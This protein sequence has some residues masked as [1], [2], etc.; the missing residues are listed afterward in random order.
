MRSSRNSGRGASGATGP[1]AGATPLRVLIVSHMHP[2]VTRGGAEIAAYQMYTALRE[3]PGITAWFCGGASASMQPPLGTHVFQPFGPDEFVIGNPGYDH[4][5]HSANNPRFADEFRDLV[6]ELKPDVVHFH[7]FVNLGVEALLQVKQAAPEARIVL[8]LHE[9]LAICYHFGQ[10]VKRPGMELCEA[11]SP[12][13]CA[14]CFP[15]K[16]D[17]DFFMRKLYIQRFMKLADHFISP[18]RFLADRYIAWG[19]E[20]DR[21]SVIENGQPTL[22]GEDQP[23]P[24]PAT[25]IVGFFGQLSTLKGVGL[26]MDA[27]DD[28]RR[29]PPKRGRLR[30]EI[31]GDASNQPPVLRE[32]VERRLAAARGVVTVRGPYDHKR[33]KSLMQ[34]CHAVLVPSIWWENSPMVIQEAFGARRPVICSDIGGMAEKVRHGVD[35]FHFRAR[36]ATSLSDLLRRLADNPQE[37]LDLQATLARPPSVAETVAATLALY[38]HAS[39]SPSGKELNRLNRM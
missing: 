1:A 3:M 26:L 36:S 10:M 12:H 23:M 14:R 39:S 19:L 18:S 6:A 29:R 34:A 17:N 37:V 20:A 27:A 32:E 15:E 30:L 33:V 31:S 8:T 38:G 9:Y 35:G 7:H 24:D 4:W 16:S 5:N 28:L 2:R 11:A 21:V 13:D 25:L 22:P